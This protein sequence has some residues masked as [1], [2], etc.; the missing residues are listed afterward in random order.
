MKYGIVVKFGK[1][2][3]F[4]PLCLVLVGSNP[5]DP[6]NLWACGVTGAAQSLG[7]CIVRCERSTRSMPTSCSLLHVNWV[8]LISESYAAL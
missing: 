1:H 4:K 6:T 5:T 8:A 2:V 3:G 7:L